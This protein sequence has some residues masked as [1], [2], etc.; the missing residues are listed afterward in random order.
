MKLYTCAV[1]DIDSVTVER[2]CNNSPDI[3]VPSCLVK[4][5]MEKTPFEFNQIVRCQRDRLLHFYTESEVEKVEV[6]FRSFKKFVIRNPLPVEKLEEI[7]K[8]KKAFQRSWDLVGKR[9]D[10]LQAFVAGFAG[11]FPNTS[12]VEADFSLIAFEKSP[13]RNALTDFSLE[14]ILQTKQ[15]EHLQE[16]RARNFEESVVSVEENESSSASA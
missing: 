11:V 7:Q 4:D 14:G 10:M 13:Y 6:Q 16:L 3:D 2:D 1:Y 5:L 12:T 9:F 8:G 15:F